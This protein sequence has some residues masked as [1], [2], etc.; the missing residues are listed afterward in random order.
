MDQEENVTRR[1]WLLPERPIRSPAPPA[2]HYAIDQEDQECAD[3]RRDESGTFVWLIPAD[4]T[5]EEAGEKRARD[6]QQDSDYAPARV[7]PGHEKLRD[8]SSQSADDDPRK[9][10]VRFH[11]PPLSI[12]I[13]FMWAE[14]Q[15][16]L[17][18]LRGASAAV[19]RK[20]GGQ[21]SDKRHLLRVVTYSRNTALARCWKIRG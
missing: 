5:A 6:A 16:E 15:F 13:F 9:D 14:R 17:T 11:F 12:R 19:C 7:F 10:A 1:L 2:K 21:A 8:P 3:Y 18:R 20:S 4:G